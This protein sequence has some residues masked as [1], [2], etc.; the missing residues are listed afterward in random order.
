LTTQARKPLSSA[1]EEIALDKIVWVSS[2]ELAAEAL[3]EADAAEAAAD[4]SADK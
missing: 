3:A 1:F 4:E 2:D